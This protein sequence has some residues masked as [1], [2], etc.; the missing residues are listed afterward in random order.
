[1]LEEFNENLAN[2][3]KA[4]EVE[5]KHH[6]IDIAGKKCSFSKYICNEVRAFSKADSKN[7]KWKRLFEIFEQYPTDSVSNRMKAIRQLVNHLQN[8]FE[9]P[10]NNKT[11]LLKSQNP[12]NVDVMYVKGVGPR[13][14]SLLNKVGIYTA[15]DL[16]HYFPKKHL[17]YS[18]R[19]EIKD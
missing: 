16:L 19:T 8:P 1:M 3:K 6:F 11:S 13:V 4:I 10:E 12:Q 5:V 18:T 2:I 9:N 14:A 15:N 17:D 7:P